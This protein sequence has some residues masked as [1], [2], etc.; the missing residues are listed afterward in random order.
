MAN[1]QAIFLDV[2]GVITGSKVGQ[3]TPIP[4]VD[5]LNKLKSIHKSGISICLCTARASFCTLDIVKEAGLDGFHITDNGSLILNPI[6]GEIFEQHFISLDYTS[7]I[8]SAILENNIPVYLYAPTCFFIQ[9][10]QVYQELEKYREVFG[11]LPTVTDDL[12]QKIIE[13]NVSGIV[14]VTNTIFEKEKVEK[15]LKDMNL[16]ITITWTVNPLMNSSQF[17]IISPKG[18]SKQTGII[19]L[20]SKLGVSFD[21]ILGVGDTTGDWSFIQLCK[22]GGAVGNASES[23]KTLVKSKG[24]HG[25]IG[26]NVDEN[27]VIGIL[28]YFLKK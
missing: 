9:S 7:K 25:F 6:T 26:K 18:I 3:N 2:D 11:I 12:L 28:D 21:N 13:I 24:T 8:V 5:V 4:H 16:E 27:G 17:A 14:I 15:I 1:I 19:S 23:L 22:Y 10:N 20:S